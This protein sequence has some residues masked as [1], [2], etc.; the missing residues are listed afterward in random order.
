MGKFVLARKW[1]FW[2][3]I[4]VRRE[5][6][7]LDQASKV[8]FSGW[9][10]LRGCFFYFVALRK[11]RFTDTKR[12]SHEHLKLWKSWQLDPPPPGA[13]GTPLVSFSVIFCHFSSIM[14]LSHFWSYLIISSPFHFF[15]DIYGQ[16]HSFMSFSII[17]RHFVIFTQNDAK[18]CFIIFEHSKGWTV[19][20]RISYQL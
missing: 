18:S 4:R 7:D 11:G 14:T 2:Q 8:R 5:G 15:S 20:I 13:A 3:R 12:M 1:A 16:F 17:F 10:K 9:K 19:N 6:A